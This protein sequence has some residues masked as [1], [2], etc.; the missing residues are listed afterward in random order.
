[1]IYHIA[2]LGYGSI[3][4][5]HFDIVSKM[6][7]NEKILIFREL[8]QTKLNKRKNLEEVNV[9]KILSYNFKNLIISNPSNH[10]FKYLSLLYK[11]KINFF[12]EKPLFEKFYEIS[13]IIKFQKKNSLKLQSGYLF[14]YDELFNSF[15]RIINKKIIKNT[16][17]EILCESNIHNWR[18]KNNNKKNI[19][20]SKSSGGGV[21][22]ELSHEI[23]YCLFLFGYPKK[24]LAFNFNSNKIKSCNV[25]DQSD[26][27]LYY[28]NNIKVHIRLAFNHSLEKRYCL[29]SNK[30]GYYMMDLI[31]RDIEISHRSNY[32]KINN[33]GS[34]SNSYV[35][36]IENFFLNKNLKNKKNNT[37]LHDS[38]KVLKL[39]EIIEN[40]NKRKK[41]LY[42]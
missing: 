28:S 26:I 3:G 32:K 7:P 5:K 20:T 17:I 31:S 18:K 30:N 6:Y 23:D 39:I 1:M 19:S 25:D 22:N 36:Q 14:R 27:F 8:Y 15:K 41:I 16:S 10:H 37:N 42:T 13:H 24:V 4:K 40:S 21:L 33:F 29:A 12:I 35:R 9:K 11:K 34:L 2:I 38:L